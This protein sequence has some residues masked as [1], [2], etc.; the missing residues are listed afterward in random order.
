M[1][2]Y[3][4]AISIA[5]S[6]MVAQANTTLHAQTTSAQG[7]ERRSTLTDIRKSVVR[8]M[9]A[10]DQ[11]VE[12]IVKDNVLIVL[13]VNSNMNEFDLCWSRQR[14]NCDCIHCVESDFWKDVAQG[15]HQPSSPLIVRKG[16]SDKTIDTVEFRED[17]NG[18]FQHHQT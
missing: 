14:S 11:T 2:R 7:Q 17:T 15:R 6:A 16:S 3:L 5:V 12:V 1:L 8:S 18:M 9:G 13:R 4:F 10:T